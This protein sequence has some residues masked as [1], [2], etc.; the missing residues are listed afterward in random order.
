MLFRSDY[1]SKAIRTLARL[2]VDASQSRRLIALATI[3]DGASRT[4]AA[5]TGDVSLQVIRDWVL[6]FNAEGP[7]GLA[8]R[9]APGKRP[10]LDDHHR[11]ALM[12]IVEEGPTLSRHGVVRW[13]LKDLAHWISEEFGL[14]LDETTVSR[15]LHALGYRKLTARPRHQAQE[16]GTR[17]TFKKTSPP[18]WRKSGNFSRPI[19]K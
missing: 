14:S 5:R 19:Q 1:T 10:K 3:Y 17:E 13:R 4:A 18:R 9:K 8:T 2:S 15:E 11:A 16:K 7:S 12:K 6:R